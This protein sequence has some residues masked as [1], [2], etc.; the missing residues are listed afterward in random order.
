MRWRTEEESEEDEEGSL[1][2]DGFSGVFIGQF[3]ALAAE[4]RMVPSLVHGAPHDIGK[5]W[6]EIAGGSNVPVPQGVP[7]LGPAAQ[8][9]SQESV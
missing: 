7:W 2:V 3:D 4:G 6:R 9:I 1:T 5:H 8:E